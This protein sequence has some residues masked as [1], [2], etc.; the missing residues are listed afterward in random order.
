MGLD[1]GEKMTV[2]GFGTAKAVI[3]VGKTRS[4]NEKTVRVAGAELK[5]F[6]VHRARKGCLLPGKIVPTAV[7]P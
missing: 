2:I 5:K 3:V 1:A 7:K 6:I 4:G